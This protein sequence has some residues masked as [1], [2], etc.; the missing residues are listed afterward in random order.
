MYVVSFMGTYTVAGCQQ[1]DREGEE[2][3]GQDRAVTN[4]ET[5]RDDDNEELRRDS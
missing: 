1:D 2:E 5:G 4:E 3:R